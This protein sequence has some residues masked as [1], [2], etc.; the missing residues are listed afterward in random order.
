[1]HAQS[2]KQCCGRTFLRF[3]FQNPSRFPQESRNAASDC[4][5][6]VSGSAGQVQVRAVT[7]GV[8]VCVCVHSLTCAGSPCPPAAWDAW[9]GTS[10]WPAQ[11]P[12]PRSPSSSAPGWLNGW[13]AS[14][15]DPRFHP[16]VHEMTKKKE[17][18]K[19]IATITKQPNIIYKLLLCLNVKNRTCGDRWTTCRAIAGE[20]RGLTSRTHDNY[21]NKKKIKRE[22]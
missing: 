20:L 4:S 12:C 18:K 2:G 15:P 22:L 10:C 3:L 13:D 9:D 6:S 7:L 21:S 5:L 14:R 1:M 16:A 17:K 19:R 11:P 8:C